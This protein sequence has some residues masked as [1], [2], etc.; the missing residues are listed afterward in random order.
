MVGKAGYLTL[1]RPKN[2]SISLFV[3]CADKSRERFLPARTCGRKQRASRA[4]HVGFTLFALRTFAFVS[5]LSP[6]V[7]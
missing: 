2:L 3:N 6:A 5:D 7:F 4:V 1:P